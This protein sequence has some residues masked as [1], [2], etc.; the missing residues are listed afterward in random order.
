MKTIQ[1]S[2]FLSLFFSFIASAQENDFQIWCSSSSTVDFNVILI[3][4][5][6]FTKTKRKGS[7]TFKQ[8]YRFRENASLLSKQFSDFR[9]KLMINKRISFS[10][11]YRYSTDWRIPL[12][13]VSLLLYPYVYNKNRYYSDLIIKKK[14]NKRFLVY[15]RS[16]YLYQGNIFDYTSIIREKVGITYN[17]RKTKLDPESSVELFYTWRETIDKIRYTVLI[18]YPISKNLDVDLSYRIQQDFYVN[19]PQTLF[20]FGGKLSYKL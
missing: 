9:I 20:I 5:Q 14:L 18:S 13:S 11:G 17:I 3:P 4:D 16:R 10:L 6:L 19:N 1:N 12:E 8:G 2:I 7:I 15:L